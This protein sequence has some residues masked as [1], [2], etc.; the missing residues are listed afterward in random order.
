MWSWAS[1]GNML[2]IAGKTHPEGKSSPY[3]WPEDEGFFLARDQGLP[4]R[5]PR[6]DPVG[7]VRP[8]AAQPRSYG[9]FH[10]GPRRADDAPIRAVGSS[11]GWPQQGFA[12]DWPEEA[13][14][15][16]S[17]FS[18]FGGS[19]AAPSG[20]S[21]PPSPS[22]KPPSQQS[23]QRLPNWKTPSSWSMP[24]IADGP[25][26]TQPR[27]QVPRPP[28]GPVYAPVT[29]PEVPAWREQLELRKHM[30]EIE[31]DEVRL[32]GETPDLVPD[33]HESTTYYAS[34]HPC[35]D[36]MAIPLEAPKHSKD[37]EYLVSK[38]VKPRDAP[39]TKKGEAKLQHLSFKEKLMLR[40]D[41]PIPS[42]QVLL[43]G[44]RGNI[45]S[46][47]IV[48]LG[49]TV[50]SLFDYALQRKLIPWNVLDLN[51]P[52]PIAEMFMKYEV[53]TTPA[54]VQLLHLTDVQRTKV[55]LHWTPPLNDHGSP[56]QGYKV[57]ILLNNPQTGA[58]WQT[59]CECTKTLYTSYTVENLQG[60]TDY[61]INVMAV[62]EVGAGDPN[63]FQIQTAPVEPSPPAKPWIQEARDGCLCVAWHASTNDGGSPITTYK[64]QM[65][66]LLGATSNPLMKLF[67]PSEKDAAW[68]DIGS[69]GAVMDEM[70]DQPSIYT[71]WAGPLDHGKCEYRFRVYA[72]SQAGVSAPSDLCDP[73][74]TS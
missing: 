44:R 12:E 27:G 68:A 64:V 67:G 57:E 46:E 25:V 40:N 66:K 33:W 39:K 2:G 5:D 17:L 16:Q 63:E 48:L 52:T 36:D 4:V 65:M 51:V 26:P 37:G 62:N 41:H 55:T 60:N 23:S 56:V 43:W 59:L 1:I 15:W 30:V 13:W 54:A 74:Y 38:S 35:F 34:F 47:E 10:A 21:I 61:V 45:A 58:Q 14:T 6:G 20:P 7:Q 22:A 18:G 31:L 24:Q 11:T 73:H 50:I 49:K 32:F 53:K 69:V 9:V 3:Q 29:S 72:M 71:V 28:P 19:R 8:Y 70:K 42:C